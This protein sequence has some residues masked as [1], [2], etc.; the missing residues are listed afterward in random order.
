MV[1]IL[2]PN[3]GISHNYEAWLAVTNDG[4]TVTGLL[5]SKTDSE[6]VL[7]DAAGIVYTLK[8]ADVD[9]LKKLTTSLMPADLQKLLT[10]QDLVDVVDFLTTLKKP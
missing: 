3:A 2:D 10:P 6:V 1:S 4:K 5:V 8:L 7:K 9:E